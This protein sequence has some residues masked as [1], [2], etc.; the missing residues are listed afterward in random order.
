MNNYRGINLAFI[1]AKVYNEILLNGIQIFIDTVLMR[2][3]A[4]CFRG[5]ICTQQ[6]CT[7]RGIIEG[8]QAKQLPLVAKFI[9]GRLLTPST[10]SLC[11]PYCA[12]M[13]SIKI[14][15]AIRFL[16]DSSKHCRFS[17]WPYIRELRS[18]HRCPQRGRPRPISL[19]CRLNLYHVT[20]ND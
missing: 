19:H 14:V 3:Q 1:C 12:I 13:S 15:S 4:G 2:N 8:L 17:W 11:L 10:K 18:K 7:L 5:R 6:I 9:E 20:G 16:R